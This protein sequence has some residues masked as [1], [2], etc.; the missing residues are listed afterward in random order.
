ME[1]TLRSAQV[2]KQ[3]AEDLGYEGKEIM[4][5][6]KEQ[7][8]F[9]REERA[10]WRNIRMTE[11]Q[12]EAEEKRRADEIKVQMAKI[13]AE[14]ELTLREMELKAQDQAS[15]SLAATP[16]PRNKDAKSPKLPSFIDEKDE[17][18]S[19]LLCFERYAENASWEKDTWAIK[20]SALLTGRAMD[21]YTRM[22][23]A[24]ASDYDKLKKALLTRYNYTEDGYRKRFREATPETEETP[25]QF[26]IR[27]KNY[28][29]KWLEL[30]GSSPQNFDALVDLTVKEQFINTCSEDLAMY[31]L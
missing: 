28:L 14:K 7:Q 26:V 8:K 2:L 3:E 16:P 24:D 21:V 30:S 18:D 13:E 11:L 17:L 29:A 6:V 9:D 10:A 22:S 4:E 5:Y 12:T 20:L 23:D 27:L 31:L 25:D 19:Y 1:P 15:A